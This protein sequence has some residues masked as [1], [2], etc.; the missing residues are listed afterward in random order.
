FFPSVPPP[1]RS[2]LFPYTTLFR[3]V[4][5]VVPAPVGE[6]VRGH[7]Q[8]AH[9]QGAPV[10][11]KEV[12]TGFQGFPGRM[13]HGSGAAHS[14]RPF[15]ESHTARAGRPGKCASKKLVSSLLPSGVPTDSGWNWTP[16]R[17]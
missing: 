6:G 15:A 8:D 11:G 12:G 14:L 2:T 13:D 16:S 3:S 4:Q 1:P 7:V 17:G 9:H 5:P 10:D